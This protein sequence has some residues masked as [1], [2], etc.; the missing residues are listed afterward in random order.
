MRK[1]CV[2]VGVATVERS[3]GLHFIVCR[4]GDGFFVPLGVAIVM[5]KRKKKKKDDVSAHVV[6]FL[7]YREHTTLCV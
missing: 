3:K 1:K 7:I 2:A 6:V 5:E 4:D